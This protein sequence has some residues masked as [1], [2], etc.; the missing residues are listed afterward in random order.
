ML[1]VLQIINFDRFEKR[2][3]TKS[4]LRGKRTTRSR[5]PSSLRKLPRKQLSLPQNHTSS[6]L[7]KFPIAT[8][9][10]RLYPTPLPSPSSTPSTTARRAITDRTA[11]RLPL[12][13]AIRLDLDLTNRFAGC[14]TSSPSSLPVRHTEM[15]ARCKETLSIKPLGRITKRR[16]STGS[17]PPRAR[18]PILDPHPS[19]VVNSHSTFD[20]ISRIRNPSRILD[21]T[22]PSLTK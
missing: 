15:V 13:P 16:R 3:K 12:A 4:L 20:P 1:S 2:E 10:T 9:S 17:R 22:F 19:V 18:G 8:L 11:S 7:S 6:P 5:P 21:S 14:P